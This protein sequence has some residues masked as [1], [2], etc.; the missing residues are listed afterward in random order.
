MLIWVVDEE[1]PMVVPCGSGGENEIMDSR[2]YVVE[3]YRTFLL[4]EVVSDS[5]VLSLIELP[6]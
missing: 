3:I 1:Y 6:E 2:A 5:Q 4:L